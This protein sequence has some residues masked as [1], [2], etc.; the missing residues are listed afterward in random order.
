[1][2]NFKEYKNMT[3]SRREA[4]QH[5]TAY[6]NAWC[7][8]DAEAVALLYSNDSAGII[9]NDGEPWVGRAGVAEMARGFMAAFPDMVLFMDYFHSSGTHAVYHW[10]LEGHN[11]GAGGTGNFVRTPGWEYWRYSD[12]GLVAAS[13]GHFDAE[14]Y[15]R[16]INGV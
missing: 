8:H 2:E 12:D 14:D 1:M 15:A 3:I 6:T 10:T 16:Q 4:S 5:A 7:E 13:L 11:T 9:I